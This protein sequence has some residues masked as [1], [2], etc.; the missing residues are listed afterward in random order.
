MVPQIFAILD[1]EDHHVVLT[2]SF[3]MSYRTLHP[4]LI[5]N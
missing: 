4:S 1:V 5:M 2:L 3:P